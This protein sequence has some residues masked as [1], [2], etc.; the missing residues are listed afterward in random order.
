MFPTCLADS[1]PTLRRVLAVEAKTNRGFW[2]AIHEELRQVPRM[3]AVF[4]FVIEIFG[5]NKA[6]YR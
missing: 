2:I 5:A 6:F 3:A 4:D 1:E